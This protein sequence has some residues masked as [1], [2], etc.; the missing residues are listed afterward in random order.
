MVVHPVFRD[1]KEIMK[2]QKT[3]KRVEVVMLVGIVLS[4]SEWSWSLVAH[5]PSAPSKIESKEFKTINNFRATGYRFSDRTDT[6]MIFD[7][8]VTYNSRVKAWVKNFQGNGRAWFKKWLERSYRYIPHIQKTLR[9]R[10]LPQDLAYISMIESGFSARAV[11]S[12][13]AVGYWQFIKGTS[14]RYGLTSNWWLDERR[15]LEKSTQAAANYLGDLYKMF[16]SWELVAAAYNVGENRILRLT[17]KLRT[18]DFWIL[19]QKGVLAQET[20]HYVPKLMAAMLI[21]KAPALYG[22]RNLSAL[23]PV[24]YQT[25]MAPGGTYLNAIADHLGVT[26]NE[27]QD[28]NA[29]LIKGFIPKNVSSHMIRVPKG[30][31]L[32]VQ[33]YIAKAAGKKGQASSVDSI[34]WQ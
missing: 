9:Q 18:R 28:L 31:R 20:T 1:N 7:L 6:P 17:E 8:P 13:D 14:Q 29:E 34:E 32:Y 23:D 12:A 33:Q 16:G 19:A 15:D 5:R 3:K 22:F 10:G 21:A 25:V 27:L 24:E 11:S 2:R 26:R 4:Y 30:S